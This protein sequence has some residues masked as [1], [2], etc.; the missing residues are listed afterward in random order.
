[1]WQT[2]TALFQEYI[3]TGLIFSWFLVILCYLW[4][5]EKRKYLRVIFIYMPL[6]LLAIFFNPWLGGLFYRYVAED[7]YYRILWL[8]PVTVV[9]SYGIVHLFHHLSERKK[10]IFIILC[11]GL[12]L[13][14]GRYIYGDVHFQKAENIYHMPQSVVEICDFIAV[15]GREVMAAFPKEMIPFV[16]QYDPTVCMPYGR[17]VQLEM[18]GNHNPFY[19]AMDASILDVG[20][21]TRMAREEGCHFVIVSGTKE[22]VGTFQEYGFK[23]LATFQHYEVYGDQENVPVLM[24]D[25]HSLS[26]KIV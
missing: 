7:I 22:K 14:S 20:E 19:E 12:I 21:L 10:P 5:K 24:N 9:I 11:V 1:M 26:I 3:G 4:V 13:V 23:L 6:V 25:A 18:W 2:I 8:L 15:D 17:E 16:R